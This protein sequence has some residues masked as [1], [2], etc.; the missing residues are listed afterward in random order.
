MRAGGEI[1]GSARDR[2]AR[3]AKVI[4]VYG[5]G[6]HVNCVH[7]Q[8]SVDN[9]GLEIDKIIPHHDGPG[10]I[11][12]NILPSCI[13]CNRTRSDKTTVSEIRKLQG[14]LILRTKREFAQFAEIK[15]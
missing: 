8:I 5:D 2:R 12:A 4:N 11:W 3:R 15:V 7:C 1:R 9:S 6:I 10:Y 13:K 14:M